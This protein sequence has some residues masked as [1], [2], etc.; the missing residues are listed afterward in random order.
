MDWIKVDIYTN[1]A[2]IEPLTGRLMNV[3]ITGFEIVDSTDFDDFLERK[4]GNWDYYDD[5]LDEL[6]NAETC[7]SVYLPENAQGAEM[8]KAAA[9]QVKALAALGEDFGRL[10][11]VNDRHLTE[12]DWENNWKQYFKPFTVGK[13]LAVKPSWEEFADKERTVLEIDP[14]SSFGTGQH[15]TT[16]LCLEFLD[17]GITGGEKILDLGCGSGILGIAS[18]LLGAES[19]TAVDIDQNSTRIAA[20]NFEKNHISPDKYTI[21][22][23]NIL[24]DEALTDKLGTGYDLIT[25]NIVADV[26]IAMAPLFGKFLKKGGTLIVSGI[27]SQRA[28]E[29]RQ[30]L[31]ANGFEIKDERMSEDWLA[32]ELK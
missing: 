10:A 5:S 29:V 8:M 27:I 9:E 11:I 6:K 24:T 31:T 30:A 23:G 26:L 32:I 20:E 1:T 18:L 12:A 2:G 16:R 22:T 3:G 4:D 25:A 13:R 21:Y 14:G 19:V 17:S 7:L 15:N 28:D